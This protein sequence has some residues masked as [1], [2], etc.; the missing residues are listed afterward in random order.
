METIKVSGNNNKH[1][2]LVY[3]ISTCGWCKRAKNFLK[4]NDVEYEYV[5]IDVL[6]NEDKEKIKQDII[7]RGGPLV[8]P[9]LIIDNKILITGA[10]Q[11]KLK[12]ILEL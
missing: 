4:E 2:V 12:E 1:H 9:T 6:N 10:P 7:T 5:D 11:D 3:A 8:Y